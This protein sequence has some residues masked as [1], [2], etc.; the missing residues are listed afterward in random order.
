[1]KMTV[2]SGVVSF[3]RKGQY[4]TIRRDV[5]QLF[6]QRDADTG[7]FGC[8]VPCLLFIACQAQPG[9][10]RASWRQ[11]MNDFLMHLH[12]IKRA[13]PSVTKRHAFLTPTRSPRVFH[14]CCRSS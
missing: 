7:Y 2:S 9:P 6:R 8:Q 5:G 4:E 1:M 3:N 13:D 11:L 14:V 10:T 12:G